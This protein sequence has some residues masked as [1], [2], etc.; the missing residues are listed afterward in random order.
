M[1]RKPKE[2]KEKTVPREELVEYIKN[3]CE[4]FTCSEMA[5]FTGYSNATIKVLAD[6]AG[7]KII[8]QKQREKDY[9][10]CNM[11][12]TIEV[13]A[14]KLDMNIEALK[15]YY[16]I[17]GI[18]PKQAGRGQKID[19]NAH[20]EKAMRKSLL[21]EDGTIDLERALGP[22][23]QKYNLGV[24]TLDTINATRSKILGT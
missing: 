16:R 1:G 7:L 18:K 15:S 20:K 2:E 17:F 21:K 11:H 22:L 3:N 19:M 9:V 10:T 5:E 13:Q 6:Q 23:A 4:F 24:S 12:L 14:Q 8:T